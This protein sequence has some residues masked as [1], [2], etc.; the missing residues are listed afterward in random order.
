[1]FQCISYYLP[2]IAR[3]SIKIP[4]RITIPSIGYTSSDAKAWYRLLLSIIVSLIL[5][6]VTLNY[7][8]YPYMPTKRKVVNAYAVCYKMKKTYGWKSHDKWQRCVD[9][10]KKRRK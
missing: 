8:K 3:G 6:Y 9:K 5:F 4:I 7:Y 2:T 10:I 1:V